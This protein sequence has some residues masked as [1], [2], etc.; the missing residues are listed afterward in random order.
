MQAMPNN[1]QDPRN[2]A[3]DESGL[4]STVNSTLC[5]LDYSSHRG[6]NEAVFYGL[7]FGDV[8]VYRY[9]TPVG[10]GARRT[11]Q[12][13]AT[14]RADDF[15][16]LLP[17][18]AEVEVSQANLRTTIEPASFGLLATSRPFES[19]SSTSSH[20]EYLIKVSGLQLRRRLPYIEKCC[21]MSLQIRPGAGNL[22]STL[23]D[24]AL[25]DGSELPSISRRRLGATIV[26]TI[27]TALMLAPELESLQ[28]P[29]S[30]RFL[31][32]V[33]EN[34]SDY[35]ENHLANPDLSPTEIAEHC[36]I[37]L[38]T[39]HAAFVGSGSTV[40]THIRNLRLQRCRDELQSPV[41]RGK[42]IIEIALKWGFNDSAHFSHVY[43]ATFGKTPREDRG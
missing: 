10:R 41:F 35:I 8:S 28:V 19:G 17:L 1:R 15:L 4:R 9:E 21:A 37:S 13:I 27:A 14:D 32:R 6:A 5:L 39:L 12:H 33:W 43:K 29:S 34:A 23:I 26:D 22:M 16:F 30:A 36:H 42:S 25:S 24:V 2:A 40:S 38:R 7:D 11:L 3:F 31:S 18:H 20:T